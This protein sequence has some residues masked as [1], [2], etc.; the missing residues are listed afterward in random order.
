M[1]GDDNRVLHNKNEKGEA[2]SKTTRFPFRRQHNGVIFGV[3]RHHRVDVAGRAL[4]KR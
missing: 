3:H 4:S 2:T 1:L